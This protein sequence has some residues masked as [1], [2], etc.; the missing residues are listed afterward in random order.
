MD[1]P[2][3]TV[4]RKS[5]VLPLG[6]IVLIVVAL[7]AWFGYNSVRSQSLVD[8][9][10]REQFVWSLVPAQPD[11]ESPGPRTSIN[12]QIADVHLPLGD[13]P[14]ACTIVD[15]KTQ[16]LL[17]GELSGVV[18]QTETDGIE[19]AIF[20]EDDQLV[21]KKGTIAQGSDRGSNF[22]PIVKDGASTTPQQ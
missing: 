12:L 21:L 14:G 10:L 15:G 1:T 2:D 3:N 13:Y 19:L 16:A 11:P 9:T 5:Y 8:Q 17:S 18:C 20:K 7:V 6:I 22:E 4:A